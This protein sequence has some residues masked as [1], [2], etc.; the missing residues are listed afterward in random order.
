M[1]KRPEETNEF[2]E[3]FL[4][5]KYMDPSSAACAPRRPHFLRMT[6]RAVRAGRPHDSRRDAGATKK[7][8]PLSETRGRF[9]PLRL[10][11]GWFQSSICGTGASSFPLLLS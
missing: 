7:S 4:K 3:L 10:S 2:A 8:Q 9:R 1:R 11:P 6:V 5:R